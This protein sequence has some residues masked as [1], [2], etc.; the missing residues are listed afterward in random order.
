MLSQTIC[1]VVL[2]QRWNCHPFCKIHPPLFSLY[3]L[4]DIF[5]I[6]VV[7]PIARQYSRRPNH[8]QQKPIET[9]NQIRISH[10]TYN[11][12]ASFTIGSGRKVSETYF[13]T[14]WIH[15]I[16]MRHEDPGIPTFDKKRLNCRDFTKP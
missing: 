10:V 2:I 14:F 5:D 7:C 12:R 6:S 1:I 15:N 9:V 13:I 16:I 11:T 4:G 8:G 3:L